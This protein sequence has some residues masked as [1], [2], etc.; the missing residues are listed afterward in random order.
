LVGDHRRDIQYLRLHA[1]LLPATSA[2]ELQQR[3]RSTT[4]GAGHGG[5]RVH[6]EIFLGATPS[7]MLWIR[8]EGSPVSTAV[9]RVASSCLQAARATR[10]APV[11]RLKTRAT[12]K[13][14]PCPKVSVAYSSP[15]TNP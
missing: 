5:G 13:E 15:Q 8:A 12:S 14:A 6:S 9:F 3:H 7:K 11:S 2:L 1:G 4:E 10:H